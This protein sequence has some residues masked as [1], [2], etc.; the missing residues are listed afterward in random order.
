M[1]MLEEA[2]KK[3]HNVVEIF[4]AEKLAQSD[5]ITYVSTLNKYP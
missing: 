3:H 4:T 5:L 2:D 1:K